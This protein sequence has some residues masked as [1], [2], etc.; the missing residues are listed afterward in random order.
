MNRLTAAYE[1]AVSLIELLAAARGISLRDAPSALPLPG[2]LFDMNRFFQALL[3]RFLHEHL[4]GYSVRDEAQLRGT[5]E[6]VPGLNPRERRAPVLRPDIMVVESGTPVAVL[7]AK[8]RDL[9]EESLSREMLY[10]VAIYAAVHADRTATILYPTSAEDARE[11]RLAVSN[12]LT[13][14]H[15]ATVCLR[16]VVLPELEKLLTE[17]STAAN[18]RRRRSFARKL[19]FGR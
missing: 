12:P 15:V 8:Y 10:Q 6:Y 11:S 7:D 14:V 9:W 18:D 19:A 17:R 13:G 5:I 1:P 3:S 16:P 4:A 2:F